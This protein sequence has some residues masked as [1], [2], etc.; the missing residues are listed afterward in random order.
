MKICVLSFLCLTLL[1]SNY[2][3]AQ[4][5]ILQQNFETGTIPVG[6]IQNA[7][8]GSTGWQFGTNNTVQSPGFPIP[9]HSTFAATNDNYCNCDASADNLYTATINLS[10]YSNAVLQFD[11][12]YTGAMASTAQ[13]LISTNGGVAWTTLANIL[14]ANTWQTRT[15]SLKSYAGQSNLKIGFRFND[16]SQWGSGYA[17]DNIWIYAPSNFDASIQSLNISDYLLSGI[18]KNISGKLVNLG[19]TTLTS[20]ALN[21]TVNGLSTQTQNITGLNIVSGAS[22][23]FVHNIAYTPINGT[24]NLQVWASNLNGNTDQNTANDSYFKTIESVL[25][26]GKRTVIAEC[27]TSASCGSCAAQYPAF[28]AL[29]AANTANTAVI[30]YHLNYPGYDP[31][32]DQNPSDVNT[33]MSYYNLQ[34]WPFVHFDGNFIQAAPNSIT[35]AKINDAISRLSPYTIAINETKIGNTATINTTITSKITTLSAPLKVYV[36]VVEQPVDYANPP[37][38]TNQ[39]HFEYVMRDVLNDAN[40]YTTALN[41]Q[42]SITTSNTYTIPSYTNANNLKTLVFVQNYVTKEIYQ[43][44]ISSNATG[45]NTQSSQ[46]INGTVPSTLVK[47]KIFVQGAFNGNN[48]LST[49]LQSLIPNNQ[50]FTVLPHNYNGTEVLNTLT[51]NVSNWVLLELRT[52]NGTLLGGNIVAKRAALLWSDGTLHDTDGS[53][54]V[55]FAVANGTYYLVVRAIGHLAVMSA[56]PINCPNALSYDFT[57]SA[58]QAF[59]ANQQKNVNGK[60]CLFSGDIDQSGIVTVSD[61]NVYQQ[62]PSASNVYNVRDL[63]YDKLITVA[64]YNL[65]QSN[66]SKTGIVQI[67]Y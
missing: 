27:F 24:Q 48:A 47:A 23:D 51:T 66:T 31:M 18:P 49:H 64:D 61:F 17:I 11:A 53:E 2:A 6:W 19:N 40:T 43:S 33:K 67:R 34:G 38:T 10:T 14:P 60:Y 25:Q 5:T 58:N 35:Q 65:F 52:D 37:S 8:Q 62:Q 50:P 29:M 36:C 46:V 44:L 15:Y 39:K 28:D 16:N 13:V 57:S 20:V 30:Q 12:F 26:L 4:T 45:T 21:Y 55:N 41:A 7:K 22:Y 63:N 32:Y 54:G 42:Q 9:A 1:L 59:G 56:V 3:T